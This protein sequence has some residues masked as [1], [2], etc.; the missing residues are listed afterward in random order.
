MSTQK[1][2]RVVALGGGYASIHLL[3]SLRSVI[4]QGLVHLTVIDKNNYHVFHGLVAEMLTGKI[5]PGTITSPARMVFQGADFH[6]GEVKHVDF[7]QKLVTTSRFIDGHEYTVPY[8]HLVVGLGSRDNL[9]RYTGVAQNTFRL[10]SYWDVFELKNHITA[11]LELA[12]IET[13]PAERARLQTFVIA[14]GNFAGVEVATE[15]DEFLQELT[16]KYEEDVTELAKSRESDVME[17]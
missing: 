5:Q 15:L 13:D 14:G 4:K 17:Q 10:K 16:K 3:K 8:D 12:E 7:E 9:S 11:V 6:N 2:L 1:P